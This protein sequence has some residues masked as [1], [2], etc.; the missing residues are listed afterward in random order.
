[1]M[2][3]SAH[4]QGLSLRR[5]STDFTAIEFSA[6]NINW[7]GPF[8]TWSHRE[9]KWQPISESTSNL[10]I[11]QRFMN[12]VS[13][14]PGKTYR[15]ASCGPEVQWYTKH[16]AQCW[17]YPNHTSSWDPWSLEQWRN[18][19]IGAKVRYS[20]TASVSTC[21]TRNESTETETKKK[22]RR[23]LPHHHA[24]HYMKERKLDYTQKLHQYLV[25]S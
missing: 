10:V 23:Y 17:D 14:P 3:Q 4:R 16:D 24:V 1:M 18:H 21:T 12:F 13:L 15:L 7:E 11:N 2:R 5:S 20:S 19:T 8:L 9:Q 22:F 6:D 25:P